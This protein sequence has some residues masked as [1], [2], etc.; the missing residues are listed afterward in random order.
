MLVSIFKLKQKESPKRKWQNLLY[1]KCPN[2]GSPLEDNKLYF[3]CPKQHPLNAGKSCFFIKKE[4]AAQ[5]L[6]D[7]NHPANF[8][9]TLEERGKIDEAI[10]NF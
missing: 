10:K 8:C 3:S 9:L 6:L 4:M 5:Y 2:C 7:I 1:K